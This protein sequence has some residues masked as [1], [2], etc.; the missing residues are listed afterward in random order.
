MNADTCWDWIRLVP[1]LSMTKIFG[2]AEFLAALALLAVLYTV[3]DI[4]YKFRVAVAPGFMYPL[5]FGLIAFIGVATLL[6][7]VWSSQH[8]PVF[9]TP[10]FNSALW[11][12]MLGLLFL[13]TF[14]TWTYYAY[15]R[16]PVFGYRNA[17]RF[18]GEM[19][20]LAFRGNEDEI[21]VVMSEVGYSSKQLVKHWGLANKWMKGDIQK[22][23]PPKTAE[24][25]QEIFLVL[26]DRHICKIIVKSTPITALQLFREMAESDT[27]KDF[28]MSAF[29]RNIT[30]EAVA[31][32]DSFL[33]VEV[34]GY[35][36][37]FFGYVKP[38][39]QTIYGNYELVAGIQQ[40]GGLGAFDVEYDDYT[41]WDGQQWS[42]YLRAV[43]ITMKAYLATG[44]TNDQSIVLS[45]AFHQVN[46]ACIGL[47]K[48][49]GIENAYETKAHDAFN[50]KCDFATKAIELVNKAKI[51]PYVHRMRREEGHRNIHD[52]LAEL[53]YQLCI[54]STYVKGPFMSSWV[55]Q[56]NMAW[57]AMH[58]FN[59][60]KAW[61]VVR[62]K[63]RR[64]L[65]EQIEKLIEFPNYVSIRAPAFCLNVFGLAPLDRKGKHHRQGY[66]LSCK[67][68]AWAREYYL[69]VV[70]DYPEMA[71]VM[72]T[73][74]IS[75]D[76]ENSRLVQTNYYG[77]SKKPTYKYLELL[78]P[79]TD[80]PQPN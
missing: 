15:I 24:Y 8:W 34:E 61:T 25:A 46:S 72:L 55:F 52:Q 78:P 42:A 65:Y 71:E 37:G 12:A 14:L 13:G 43:L 3:T 36:S 80:E 40:G 21:K 51:F 64:L 67:A 62:R 27:D 74:S 47:D 35:Q 70:R 4:R 19:V 7:E 26:S 76:K 41:S 49:S 32:K 29:S 68:Q 23:P 59:D 45:Q 2:F 31:Q 33:Y 63:T 22:K 6:T 30:M 1:M 58:G 79:E 54:D 73:G 18:T 60:G 5:T 77:M 9:D 17:R 44:R 57:G 10:W 16:P 50:A 53:V 66:A 28:P 39:S 75:F 48:L 20:R 69:T 38:V 56:H 11:Q